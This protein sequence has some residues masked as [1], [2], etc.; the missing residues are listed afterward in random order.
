MFMKDRHHKQCKTENHDADFRT[1]YSPCNVGQIVHES[2]WKRWMFYSIRGFSVGDN[3]SVAHDENDKVHI[4]IAPQC[5][6]VFGDQWF[7]GGALMSIQMAEVW[8]RDRYP[9]RG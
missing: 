6:P 9:I 4:A 5:L 7:V 3:S 1:N 2:I 8:Y